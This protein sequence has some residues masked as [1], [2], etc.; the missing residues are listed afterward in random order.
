MKIPKIPTVKIPKIHLP[1][2]AK[3]KR[4]LPVVLGALSVIGN[5]ISTYLFIDTT[6]KVTRIA[7]D[8]TAEGYE[9]KDIRNKVLPMYAIPAATFIAANACTVGAVMSA[10]AQIGGLATGLAAVDYR[11]RKLKGFEDE[12]V[13]VDNLPDVGPGEILFYDEYLET[14]K[15]DGYFAMKEA[16]WWK[17]YAEFIEDIQ[18]SNMF[19]DF[20]TFADFYHYLPKEKMIDEMLHN[21]GS[22]PYYAHWELYDMSDVKLMRLDTVAI[23]ENTEVKM[24]NWLWPPVISEWSYEQGYV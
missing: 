5:G 6:V 7:D 20:P 22:W 12:V 1:S 13:D 11:N 16:D 18:N 24:I 23:D 2:K 10:E 15:Q 4:A 9:K 3:I 8:M 14:G 21:I 19:P 17:A